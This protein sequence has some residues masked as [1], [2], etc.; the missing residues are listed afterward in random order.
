MPDKV[1]KPEVRK[2]VTLTDEQREALDQIGDNLAAG[3]KV[4]ADRKLKRTEH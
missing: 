1:H 2:P 3:M 4:I